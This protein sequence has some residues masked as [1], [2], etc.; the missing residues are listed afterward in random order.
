MAAEA[1]VLFLDEK[2]QKSSQQRGF[3][4][5]GPLLCKTDKTTGCIILPP[6]SKLTHLAKRR[7]A[8]TAAQALLVLSVFTRSFFAD[9]NAQIQ[10]YAIKQSF[11]PTNHGQKRSAKACQSTG[12]GVWPV[13]L[14]RLGWLDVWLLC[15]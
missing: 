10:H 2:N 5:H 1:F 9:N 15:I 12:P 4:S 6:R 3:F 8:L 13:R 14:K 7:Y 11:N